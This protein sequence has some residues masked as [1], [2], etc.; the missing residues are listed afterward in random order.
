MDKGL[1]KLETYR[2]TRV[3]FGL[4]QSPLLLGRTLMA[5]LDECEQEYLQEIA[6]I[7]ASLYVNDL[8]LG[9]ETVRKVEHLKKQC[10]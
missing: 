2:F 4:N 9:A 6:E 10:I 5:P 8:I 3:L 7:K 1:E